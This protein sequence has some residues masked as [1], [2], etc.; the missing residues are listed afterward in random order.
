MKRIVSLLLAAVMCLCLM[1][2]AMA[3]TYTSDNV[4]PVGEYPIV[5][6]PITVT[7]MGRK[8]AGAP[9]WSE[10]ELFKRLTEITGISFEFEIGET[11]TTFTEQKNIALMGR[12][13]AEIILRDDSAATTDEETYGPLGTFLDLTDLIAEYAPNI[14]AM[15]EKYPEVK[16]ASTAMDGKI[17]GLPYVFETA[18]TQGHTGFFSEE[19]MKNV[20][21][22]KVPETVDELYEMLVAFKEQDANGNGDPDDE[23]PF[24][25]AGLNTTIRRLLIPAFTGTSEGLGFDIKDGKI[26]Y[27]PALPEYKE[28][29]I[30]TNKLYTEGLLDAEFAIQT[31]QQWLAKVKANLSGVYSS[32]PTG[33]DPSTTAQQLSLPPL[34]SATNDTPMAIKPDSIYPGRAFITDRCKDPVAAIRLLDMFYATE[35]N[36]VEGFYGNTC[37]VGWEGEHWQYTDETKTAYQWIAPI[38]GFGDINLSVS[39]N[40]ELP[41]LLQFPA[42]PVGDSLM[43]MKVEQVNAM[44]KPYYKAAFP[45][46]ARYTAEESER[47]NIIEN[48]LYS[49]V[50]SM[51]VKF[52]TGE[53][54]ISE[55]DSYI[56]TLNDIGLQ[57]LLTIKEAVYQR[58]IAAMD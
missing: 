43:E 55:F 30:Y 33:L 13:Y 44:Q 48:D 34:T 17:Y 12:E 15:F 3:E 36:A 53:K 37:F 40:M 52:I 26:V 1:P 16:A 29:L 31:S 8:N 14:T 25:C 28:F 22:D 46:N 23:I 58:W 39:V 2:L 10:L 20:G 32:S 18:T 47:G 5:K 7:V 49:Y 51:T 11:G 6:T 9:D 56:K 41:G 54:P 38:T 50:T 24:T 35:E 42:M 4:N 21:I 45:I 19:W 27:A 57:E